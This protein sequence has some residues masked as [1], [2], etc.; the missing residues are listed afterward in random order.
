MEVEVESID[1][2]GNFV[3]WLFVGNVNLSV[4]LV[5]KGLAK[6]HFSAEKTAYY[7]ELQNAEEIVKAKRQGVWQGY[8]EEV[9]E[10]NVVEDSAERK[11]TYKKVHFLLIF[12]GIILCMLLIFFPLMKFGALLK[13]T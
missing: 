9:R 13:N 2:G 5:E 7:K 1:K 4:C 11:P 10:T 3:G 12:L 6:V 8:V